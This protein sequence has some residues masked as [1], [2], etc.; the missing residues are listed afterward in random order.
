MKYNLTSSVAVI[1]EKGCTSLDLGT[2]SAEKGIEIQFT[3]KETGQRFCVVADAFTKDLRNSIRLFEIRKGD[4]I[5]KE[6]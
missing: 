6:E 4:G 3:I 2:L 1:I 5:L